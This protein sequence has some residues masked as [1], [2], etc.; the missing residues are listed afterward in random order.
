MKLHDCQP[1]PNPR[2]VRIFIAEK[3]LEIPTVQVDLMNREQHSE[4]FRQLN[5]FCDVPVL[6][7]DDGTCISQVN[8]ICRYLEAAHPEPNLY[9]ADAKEQ[10]LIA[11]WDN[12]AFTQGMSAVADAFRNTA[13]GFSDHAVVGPRSYAQI[14]A[15]AERGRSRTQDFLDDL[16]KYLGEREYLA[17]DR[18]SAADITAMVTI[19]FAKWVK[20]EIPE[21]H[22]NLKRWYEAVSS[23][24]SAKA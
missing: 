19:D 12:Y 18:F 13:K 20:I 4:A 5:P 10:G 2:R 6:E 7:L 23:R 24:P 1:A 14:P 3:G 21:T 11:M 22:D 17:G 15:L 8:G 9:G 16:N